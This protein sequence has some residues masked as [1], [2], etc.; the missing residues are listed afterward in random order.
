MLKKV[1]GWTIFAGF[2][3]LMVFGA[4]NRTSAKADK[5]SNDQ[6]WT[7]ERSIPNQ[8]GNGLGNRNLSEKDSQEEREWGNNGSD[9]IAAQIQS[10]GSGNGSGKGSGEALYAEEHEDQDS[11]VIYGMVVE[12][13][14]EGIKVE[15]E[16]ASI[17]EIEGRTWRYLGEAGFQLVVGD[18]VQMTGFFEDSEFK[19]I[20]INNLTSG[21]TLQMRDESGRPYWSGGRSGN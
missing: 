19:I 21:Q 13:F 15:T 3:G 7:E 9:L 11:K 6:R 18:R 4:V 17:L 10:R 12:I 5:N 16:D 14:S 1:I 2:V 8:G 20:M